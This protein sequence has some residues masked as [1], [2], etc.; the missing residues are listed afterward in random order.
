M[1]SEYR[2][3]SRSVDLRDAE[4][5]GREFRGYAAVFDSPWS[6]RMTEQA[7]YVEKVARGVFRKVLA[8]AKQNV[9][10][11]FGHEASHM[12]LATT[13]S[14]TLRLKEDGKGLLAEA[15][16]PD[17]EIGR[18][19]AD[20]IDRGVL[21]GMSYGIELDPRRDT[22]MTR[23]AGGIYTRT[24]ARINRLLDVSLTWDPAYAATTV[25]LRSAGF[26]ATPLQELLSGT[27]AQTEDAAPVEPP[28]DGTPKAEAFWEQ[29][30]ADGEPTPAAQRKWWEVIADEY[31]RE[32]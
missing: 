14:G 20:A 19:A 23:S 2:N 21:H 22:I 31:E 18:Y 17:T 3:E 30:D 8:D 12:P 32:V 29:E 15:T 25:E 27:E 28:D 26:V 16:L 24:V 4:V 10:L 9:P 11:L 6:D 13:G 7:G 5:K 1:A